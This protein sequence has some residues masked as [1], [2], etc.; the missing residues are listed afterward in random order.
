MNLCICCGAVVVAEVSSMQYW[1]QA[2]TSLAT[3]K[4]YQEYLVMQVD[5]VP[6]SEIQRN[7][8]TGALSNKVIDISTAAAYTI[9]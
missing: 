7:S 9:V 3:A 6:Q 1:K 4:Q 5:F 2:F 8:S